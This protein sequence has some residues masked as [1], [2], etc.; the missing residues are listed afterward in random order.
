KEHLYPHFVA[1]A[2]FAVD[3]DTQ[4][5][6]SGYYSVIRGPN[7]SCPILAG[8]KRQSCVCH[9][10]P[11]VELVVADYGLHTNGLPPL[12][13]HEDNQAMI[14]VVTT[15]KNPTMRYLLERIA[16]LW[17]GCMKYV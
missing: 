17:L 3:V 15:G 6:R 7:S 12:L 2:N 13:F 16:F 10:T 1:D 5:S 4:R 14:R 8:S 9:S 11:E